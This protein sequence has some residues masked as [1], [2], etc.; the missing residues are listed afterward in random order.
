MANKDPEMALIR[1]GY[2]EF[3]AP[4]PIAVAFFDAACRGEVY[5]FES[6]YKNSQC[7]VRAETIEV[8]LTALNPVKFFA[9]KQAQIDYEVEEERKRT[10]K[11]A[12]NAQTT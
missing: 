11:R 5:K 8:T 12:A 3:A 10:E 1:I 9:A 2:Q 4:R 6:E 7:I